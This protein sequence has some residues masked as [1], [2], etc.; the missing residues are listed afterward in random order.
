MIVLDCQ[1]SE[2]CLLCY[3]RLPCFGLNLEP[4]LFLPLPPCANHSNSHSDV[5]R[6]R[7]L[8]GLT[9]TSPPPLTFPKHL[10]P[11]RDQNC[12]A[13][14]HSSCFMWPKILIIL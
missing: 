9:R 11:V 2:T 5:Q 3:S 4:G 12:L 7:A 13:L 8:K 14:L 1:R 6:F 10:G